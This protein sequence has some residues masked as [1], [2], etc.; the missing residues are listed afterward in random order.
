M[1]GSQSKGKHF[2]DLARAY[3]SARGLV[4]IDSNY[5]CR[6]GE[7]DLIMQQ[8]DCICFVEVKYRKT[9]AFG[10]A[11]YALPQSKQKKIIKAA[12]FYLNQH[13]QLAN[14]ALRFDVVFIQGQPHRNEEIN[15]IE[16][17]FYAD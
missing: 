11:I 3:L 2:E 16:N 12:M 9:M 1:T 15:W 6:F 4:Y 8:Q 17:A 13:K 5:S 10:G 7:I 14:R